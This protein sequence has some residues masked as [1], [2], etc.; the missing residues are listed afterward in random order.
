MKCCVFSIVLLLFILPM[1]AWATNGIF[2]TAQGVQQQGR[3][4][5]DLG[6]ASSPTSMQTNPA[7]IAFIPGK[8][9]DFTF[10]GVYPAV[11][12]SNA[13][14]D[15]TRSHTEL[16]PFGSF[17]FVWD[18]MGQ[19]GEAATDPIVYTFGG[20]PTASHDTSSIADNCLE[21]ATA[22]L[23][24]R[25][26]I[27]AQ[28]EN[29]AVNALR[30]Y[31]LVT[32]DT[33]EKSLWQS[34]RLPQVPAHARVLALR[35]RFAWRQE[36]PTSRAELVLRAEQ[37]ETRLLLAGSDG[38]WQQGYLLT[39]WQEAYMPAYATLDITGDIAGLQLKDVEV[40]MNYRPSGEDIW[41]VLHRAASMTAGEAT[42][43]WVL[44][45]QSEPGSE[46]TPGAQPQV[47][48]SFAKWPLLA[49]GRLQK[50]AVYYHYRLEQN[51]RN[52][53]LRISLQTPQQK[54][55]DVLHLLP[56][57]EFDKQG[58]RWNRSESDFLHAYREQ[59]AGWKFGFGIFPLAGARY[60][61]TTKSDLWPEGLEN[62]TDYLALTLAPT[63]AYRFNDSLSIGVS[64]NAN[65]QRMELDALVSQPADLM[66]GMS[67][68][69]VTFG[70]IFKGFAG[71]FV[72]G[73]VDT[74][75]LMSYGVGGRIGLLWK[76]SERLH[77]GLMYAPKPWMSGASGKATV[78]FS[79]HFYTTPFSG[80]IQLEL[81]NQGRYGFATQYDI[82][83]KM[84][85][86]QRAGAG[87]G[88]LVR[89]NLLLGLDFQWIQ[90][91]NTQF[92]LKT[93]LRDGNNPDAN[94][95][96]GSPDLDINL[97]LGWKDQYVVSF[98]LV[99]QAS[100]YWVL[101]AG[102]NYGNNPVPRSYLNP[103]FAA[104]IE[105]HVTAGVSYLLDEHVAFHLSGEGG[106]P[107]QL[108]SGSVNDVHSDFANS[109]VS[110]YT[111]GVLFGITWQF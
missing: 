53:Y 3:G 60:T 72:H 82:E 104:I 9:L 1:T 66:R 45:G 102:Y 85:L 47:I 91:S 106:L 56:A 77:L 11:N 16:V 78:D 59:P 37:E 50:V 87:L 18:S 30:V 4:G 107:S 48:A 69:G 101:R 105:H 51:D 79:R 61:I 76:I 49:N 35:V 81:P 12:F 64:L 28:G 58:R 29:A 14:N 80:F 6:I 94:T 33:A 5:A 63:V 7:G 111:V 100:P 98:G 46:F 44:L 54:G 62:R 21:L 90:Y 67:L 32:A 95:L 8:M 108:K 38:R 25:L 71:D 17:A 88:I 43:R 52:A 109:K 84:D 23:P 57:V 20:T 36:G 86:P 22:E 92:K 65:V 27:M 55:N 99:W 34:D 110:I 39:V 19:I 13:W 73:E 103:Q 40:A 93:M 41:Q 75:P 70:E 31:G 2:P 68:L 42:P 24:T 83:V 74:D 10:G 96:I 89:D 15:D 26:E 97:T